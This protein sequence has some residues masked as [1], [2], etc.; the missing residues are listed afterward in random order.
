MSGVRAGVDLTGDLHGRYLFCR[1]VVL[2]RR[3]PAACAG[4]KTSQRYLKFSASL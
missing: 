2:E 1:A 3:R 4:S